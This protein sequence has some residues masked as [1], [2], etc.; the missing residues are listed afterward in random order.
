[1]SVE[2]TPAALNQ[3]LT[4]SANFGWNDLVGYVVMVAGCRSHLSRHV[5]AQRRSRLAV[6]AD[7]ATDLVG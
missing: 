3:R 7:F 6:A 2:L 5:I 1:L 4:N